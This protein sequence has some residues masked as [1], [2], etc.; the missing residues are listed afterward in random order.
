DRQL[1]PLCHAAIEGVRSQLQRLEADRNVTAV[2]ESSVDGLLRGWDRLAVEGFGE[3]LVESLRQR[4]PGV[5]AA[6]LADNGP[7]QYAV[8]LSLGERCYQIG[9]HR[10]V[11][12]S[13]AF[14]EILQ[15]FLRQPAMDERQL[16][17]CSDLEDAVKILR[18][19]AE[20]NG[21]LFAP[22]I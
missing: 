5:T 2:A 17:Q 11:V 6:Y 19:L 14:D 4:W 13:D 7:P 12:V 22:A 10:P 18:K 16:S 3:Q 9:A 1:R 8:I 20:W 21:G 15:A